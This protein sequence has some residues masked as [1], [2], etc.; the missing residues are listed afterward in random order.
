MYLFPNMCNL[1][2]YAQFPQ[3][4]SLK[5]ISGIEKAAAVCRKTFAV[6]AYLVM[7]VNCLLTSIKIFKRTTKMYSNGM[8][9]GGTQAMP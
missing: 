4:Q 3:A 7:N 9:R 2:R 1:C 5:R 8:A 6:A